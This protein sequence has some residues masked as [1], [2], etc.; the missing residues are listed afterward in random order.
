MEN[1][2]PSCSTSNREFLDPKKKKEIESW[3]EDSSIVDSLDGLYLIEKKHESFVEVSR[4]KA[5]LL[6]DKQIPSVR[7]FD[8]NLAFGR[9]LEEIHVTWAHLE[10]KRKRLRTYTNISQ[11]Y[12]LSG[13]RRRHQFYTMPSQPTS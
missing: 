7:V 2:N 8:E 5:H 11:D 1:A 6:E 12:V 4:L 13:W 9:H 10:K 3:L